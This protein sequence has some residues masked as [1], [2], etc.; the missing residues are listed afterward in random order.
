[1]KIIELLTTRS[2]ESIVVAIATLIFWTIWWA[3]TI[4]ERVKQNARDIDG[5]ATVVGTERSKGRKKHS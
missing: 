3:A 5:V 1:M 4:S 2:D